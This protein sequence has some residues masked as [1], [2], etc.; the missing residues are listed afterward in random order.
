M[1]RKEYNEHE[2]TVISAYCEIGGIVSKASG[3]SWA[4]DCLCPEGIAQRE[5]YHGNFQY[6]LEV[7]EFIKQATIEKIARD[8]APQRWQTTESED[9]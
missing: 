3:W 2:Q 4:V 1:H 5:K 6:D 9:E 7:I 8:G